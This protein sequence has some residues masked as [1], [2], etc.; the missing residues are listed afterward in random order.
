MS[1]C[2]KSEREIHI[3]FMNYI[4]VES[5]KTGRDD[6]N[7]KAEIETQHRRGEEAYGHQEGRGGGLGD[8]D[9]LWRLRAN[10]RLMRTCRP[11]GA[12]LSALGDRGES[13]RV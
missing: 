13:K 4:Y 8:G 6:L 3:L 11:Q 10:R 1:E 5:E 9:T 2:G 7:Y 12:P